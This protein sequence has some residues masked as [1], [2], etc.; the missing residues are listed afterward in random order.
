V[1][2]PAAT[3]QPLLTVEDLCERYSAFAVGGVRKYLF[4][5]KTNGLDEA[6]A[7]LKLGSKVLIDVDKFL[8]WVRATG[9]K[10]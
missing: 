2:G 7:V 6:G 8:E 1:F 3:D 9:K 10:N 5:R 4:D